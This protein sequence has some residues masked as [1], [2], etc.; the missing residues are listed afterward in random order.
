MFSWDSTIYE[1]A[2]DVPLQIPRLVLTSDEFAIV[3][4]A[5]LFLII[6]N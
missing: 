2:F 5:G 4:M 1:S 6:I 3:V